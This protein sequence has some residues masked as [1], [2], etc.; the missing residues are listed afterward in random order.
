MMPPWL[1]DALEWLSML[2][3]VGIL[4]FIVMMTRK[5]TVIERRISMMWHSFAKEHN[6]DDT[7]D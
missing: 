1:R 6:I 5:M 3:H 2:T 4:T 7:I